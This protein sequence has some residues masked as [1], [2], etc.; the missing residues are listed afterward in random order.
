MVWLKK[1]SRKWHMWLGVVFA[2]PLCVV[3]LTTLL[4]AHDKAIPLG[5]LH[6]KA[7]LFPGYEDEK[8]T[9]AELRSYLDDGK[10]TLYLG[11]KQGLQVIR[12]GEKEVVSFFA[13]HDIRK[14][15]LFQDHVVV[16][17]RN[18]LFIHEKE[19]FSNV[20]KETIW[21]M[22][23]V[24]NELFVVSKNGL[25]HSKDLKEWEK[26]TTPQTE[27]AVDTVSLKKLTMDLH[28]GK[29]LLG[30]KRM[31][32]WQDILAFCLLFFIFTGVYLWYSKK[33]QKRHVVRSESW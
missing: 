14:L 12:K 4:M 13:N 21:D 7:S 25:F 16:G 26:I 22:S 11:Y 33:R 18:G 32:I 3:A 9:K 17:S 30:D 28:T 20:L 29:A 5:D 27:M 6:V 2:I 23:V 10:G 1:Q 24:N 19:G 15:I 31:W 8:Y